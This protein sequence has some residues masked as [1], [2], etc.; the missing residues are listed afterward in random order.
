[1]LSL[2]IE[3]VLS[4][5]EWILAVLELEKLASPPEGLELLFPA[6]M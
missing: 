1:M 5:S 2:M 3:I 4:I 6:G